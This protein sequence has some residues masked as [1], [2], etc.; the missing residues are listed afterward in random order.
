LLSYNLIGYC[1]AEERELLGNSG[2]LIHGDYGIGVDYKFD[3][4]YYN[5]TNPNN[6]IEITVE[7]I[8]AHPY[9]DEEYEFPV[10]LMDGQGDYWAS[11][12]IFDLTDE[13]FD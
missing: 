13:Q 12:R 9:A 1:T 8:A 3:L 7:S 10:Y 5:D 6:I 4:P 11:N 2:D